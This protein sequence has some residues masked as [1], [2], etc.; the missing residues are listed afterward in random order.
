MPVSLSTRNSKL[1]LIGVIDAQDPEQ[2]MENIRQNLME[3]IDR[4][5]DQI[6]T[7]AA[8]AASEGTVIN[9]SDSALTPGIIYGYSSGELVP[10][11][12][13]VSAH[14][15]PAFTVNQIVQAGASFTP[16]P[17]GGG[18]LFRTSTPGTH[19]VGSPVFLSENQGMVTSVTPTGKIYITGMVFGDEISADGTV[20]CISSINFTAGQSV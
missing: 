6:S 16:V 11:N 8:V 12:S 1:S 14:V 3:I 20:P 13:N 7:I 10:A 4:L 9:S 15:R 18:V 2:S 19:A 17:F 5:N